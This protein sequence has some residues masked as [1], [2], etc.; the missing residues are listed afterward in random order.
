MSYEGTTCPCGHKKEPNTM[1]CSDC[2]TTFAH[3]PSMPVFLDKSRA[4]ETRRH[5]AMT[6]LALARGRLSAR[7]T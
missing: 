4:P 5:A 3:H 7:T 6:L 1:L 2:M